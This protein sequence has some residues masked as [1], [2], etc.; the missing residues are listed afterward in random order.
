MVLVS[1]YVLLQSETV[2]ELGVITI[3]FNISNRYTY[4]SYYTWAYTLNTARPLADAVKKLIE[5]QVITSTLQSLSCAY[6][7]ILYQYQ[8]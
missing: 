6:G 5:R 7:E 1:L 8:L 2:F 3:D 4:H